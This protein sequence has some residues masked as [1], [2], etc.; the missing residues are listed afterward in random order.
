MTK[1][2]SC[3]AHDYFEIVCM[4]RSQV[5]V[6][7]KDNRKYYGLATDIK[8]VNKQEYLLISD[9]MNTQQILLSD[10]KQLEAIR[11]SIAPT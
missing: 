9:G 2:I 11:N 7:A 4:R 5:K 8:L 1:N 6:T 10:V 3:D